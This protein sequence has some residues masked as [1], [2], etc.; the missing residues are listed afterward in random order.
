M[1]LEVLIVCFMCLQLGAMAALL[2]YHSKLETRLD[3]LDV[4]LQE[5]RTSTGLNSPTPTKSQMAVHSYEQCGIPEGV[6]RS[7]CGKPASAS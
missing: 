6:L 7:R 1:Q 4:S 2:V 5:W 3:A